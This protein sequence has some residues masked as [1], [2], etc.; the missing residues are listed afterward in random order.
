[1]SKDELFV[2]TLKNDRLKNYIRLGYI[3]TAINLAPFIL[4]LFYGESRIAGLT[5][6][7]AT[8]LYFVIRFFIVKRK[9]AKYYLDEN[10]FFIL[11]AAWLLQSSLM[12]VLILITG[13]LFKI[14]LQPL[15]FVFSEDYIQKDFFPKKK[16]DWEALQTV[17]LKDGI[18]TLDFKDNKLLQAPVENYDPEVEVAFNEF[19]QKMMDVNQVQL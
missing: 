11:A 17:V 9:Q 10:I 14:S 15:R 18:L 6:V 7:I 19:V 12:A 1:M 3:L 16:F 5:G 4:F 8:I 13:I 2:I